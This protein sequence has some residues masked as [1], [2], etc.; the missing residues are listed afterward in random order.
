MR[1]AAHSLPILLLFVVVIDGAAGRPAVATQAVDIYTSPTDV[2][3]FQLMLNP[4]PTALTFGGTTFALDAPPVGADALDARLEFGATAQFTFC[5]TDLFLLPDDGAM[6]ID[7][8]AGS[9][10]VPPEVSNLGQVGA[11]GSSGFLTGSLTVPLRLPT[12]DDG[13][14]ALV[15]NC[16]GDQVFGKAILPFDIAPTGRSAP[17]T[18]HSIGSDD[19]S[20]PLTG[21]ATAATSPVSHSLPFT[22]SAEG[23]LSQRSVRA[24]ALAMVALGLLALGVLVVRPVPRH[25]TRS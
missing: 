17:A 25:G 20:G 4:V 21:V 8:A 7:A 5:G 9:T 3:A 10:Q 19:G 6:S 22:L 13:S 2:S 24:S 1:R 12:L 15:L 23:L 16:A 18:A 11:V 14:Y